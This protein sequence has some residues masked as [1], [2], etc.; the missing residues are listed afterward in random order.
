MRRL[1]WIA[2]GAAAGVYAVRR[3]QRTAESLAPGTLAASFQ[4]SLLEL[5]DAIREFAGEVRE[6]MAERETELRAALGLSD[7]GSSASH[8]EGVR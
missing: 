4:Q 5:A 6:G 8:V 7:D 3:L 2:A 1:F